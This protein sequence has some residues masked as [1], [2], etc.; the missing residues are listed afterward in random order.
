[1]IGKQALLA[2]FVFLALLGF[3]ASQRAL[4]DATISAPAMP[5][6]QLEQA[7][8]V[9][10]MASQTP[11]LRLYPPP[12]EVLTQA[13][14]FQRDYRAPWVSASVYER[15]R[16]AE[17]IGNQG[18]A[19]YA[20]ERGWTKIVG[21]QARGI[22]QGPDS[23]VWDSRTGTTRVLEAKGGTSEGKWTYQSWQG[24]NRNAIRSAEFVLDS[25][26]ASPLEKMAA[27]RVIKA[28]Q[29]NDLRTG[30]VKTSHVLGTPDAPR[31]EGEWSSENVAKE[32]VEI[33]RRV[34]RWNPSAASTFRAAGA[35]QSSDMLRYRAAQGVAVL[36]LAGSGLLGWDAY[37]QLIIAWKMWNDPLLRRTAL[38]YLQTGLSGG[39]WAEAGTLGFGS[40]AELGLL[41]R[42]GMSVFGRAAGKWFLPIAVGAEGLSAGIAYYEYSTGRISQR[43]FYRRTTG[44]A[45]FAVFTTGGAI[46]G[47]ALG[48]P[49]GGVGAAPGAL[50][51]GSIGALVAVPVQFVADRIWKWYYSKFDEKQRAAVDR[52]VECH[53]GL[54]ER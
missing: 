1:M 19:R 51:G 2:A 13:S 23:V 39:R 53:Y 17:R 40:A 32:A 28:A 29:A 7:G 36:G 24:T 33:E 18:R 20:T 52:A 15:I 11:A 6:S 9:S 49:A 38:P 54:S 26:S 50:A 47:G 12:V 37:Q 4:A 48:A 25:N 27:A 22:V 16:L 35:A 14:Y 30:M 45:I 41:G 44:P 8:R 3:L 31:L 34:T 46:I 21:S 43:E 42:G 10:A 5:L